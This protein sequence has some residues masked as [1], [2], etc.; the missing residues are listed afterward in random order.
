MTKSIFILLFGLTIALSSCRKDFETEPSSGALEFSKDTVYLDTVFATIG[1]STYTLKV[2]NR[3]DKDIS[4]PTLKLAKDDSKYRIM[5]DG[6]TGEDGP[7]ADNIGDGK[8]FHNVELLAN[9]SLYVFI[10]TTWDVATGNPTEFLYTDEIQFDSGSNFQKVNLVTLIRDAVF[11]YPHVVGGTRESLLLGVDENND[12]VRINGFELDANDPINGNEFVFTNAKPYVIYGYA[13]IPAGKTLQINPGARVHFHAESGM[14]VQ[15]GG[16]LKIS[17]TPS[18]PANPLENEVVF[19]GD[20]LEPDF[21]NVPGQWGTIWFRQGSINNSIEHLTLHNA[22]V[23]LLVENASLFPINNSQIYDCSNVGI[24]A[25]T[26]NI[27]SNNLVVNT[28]GQQCLAL[29]QGGTYDFTH[30][31]INNN[32]NS[33]NQLAVLLDDYRSENNVA[34]E[35]YNMQAAFKNSIIYGSNN[36]E[37]FLDRQNPITT[38]AAWTATFDHCLIKFGDQGTTLEGNPFYN[39]IRNGANGNLLNLDPK[40][41]NINRNKLNIDDTSNAVAKGN[42]AY[43]QPDINNTP[44]SSPPDLGAYQHAA[45][46]AAP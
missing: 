23:G 28:A 37:L 6:M 27:T 11:L 14:V 45:F 8:V 41:Q 26:A 12:E 46:P 19:E 4:I 24:L 42:I 1:S 9:D 36:I 33:S 32:W 34:V 25:R 43:I 40:F 31:T 39:L 15:P 44:R 21:S 17:G 35:F 18:G 20:R 38:P 5:V 3:S 10:E 22:T 29:T 16:T 13:G 2:Y 7:D 30:A